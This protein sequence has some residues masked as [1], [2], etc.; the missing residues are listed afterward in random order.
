MRRP[1]LQSRLL[2]AGG[3]SRF[4]SCSRS[5][6]VG[7]RRAAGCSWRHRT[8]WRR[9]PG[10]RETQKAEAEKVVAEIKAQQIVIEADARKAAE[11]KEAEARKIAAAELTNAI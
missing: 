9:G 4:P 8:C 5:R 11:Q 7:L 6:A 10:P 1:L 3:R 2:R